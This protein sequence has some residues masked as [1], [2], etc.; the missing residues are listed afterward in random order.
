MQPINSET[1]NYPN[2]LNLK[3]KEFLY[4]LLFNLGEG[5]QPESSYP[6]VDAILKENNLPDH[7]NY[8]PDNEGVPMNAGDDL[9]NFMSDNQ[10]IENENWGVNIQHINQYIEAPTTLCLVNLLNQYQL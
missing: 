3:Q 10:N 9:Y 4:Y 7:L 2:P 8:M 5:S 6:P 1:P